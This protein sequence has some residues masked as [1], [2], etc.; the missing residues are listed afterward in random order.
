[1][2]VSRSAVVA[3]LVAM[4]YK[5]AEK[6]DD[7]K[8]QDTLKKMPKLLKDMGDDELPSKDMAK[9]AAE[10]AEAVKDKE[11]IELTADKKAD[12]KSKKEEKP[13]KGKKAK[14]DEDEEESD[15]DEEE[16]DEDEEEE[17]DEEGTDE[18]SDEDEEEE[19][20]EEA[21]KPKKGKKEDKK[22]KKEDKDEKPKK[23]APKKESAE[24]DKFGSRE[25]S[26]AALINACIGKKAKSIADIAEESGR[27]ASH[28]RNHVR[29]LEGKKLVKSDDKG[30]VQLKTVS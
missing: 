3:L 6:W 20:E 7:Q 27:S 17:S 30:V 29:H 1:M 22:S 18:E 12:K 13:A 10:I 25:G 24:K 2:K 14:K 9:L 21:P 16:S 19:E 26:A 15:E 8:I 11:E 4:A 5:N 28:V 23:K